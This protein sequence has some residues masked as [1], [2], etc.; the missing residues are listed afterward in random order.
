MF[1]Q[2]TSRVYCDVDDLHGGVNALHKQAS[3]LMDAGRADEAHECMGA[4]LALMIVSGTRCE[5]QADFMTV[6]M[7]CL[8]G[9]PQKA[10][11]W[12]EADDE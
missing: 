11:D 2:Q 9:E 4:A 6:F 5:N 7:A 3:D 1:S 10:R 8:L 12:K